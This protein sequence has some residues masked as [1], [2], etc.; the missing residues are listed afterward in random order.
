MVVLGPN[1]H[2]DHLDTNI[3]VS[4][5]SVYFIVV[6][7]LFVVLGSFLVFVVSPNDP[8]GGSGKD[9]SINFDDPL[10][11]YPYDNAT[12]N[13]ITIKLSGTGNFL[14][15]RI[16]MSRA[17]KARYNLGFVDGTFKK[18]SVDASKVSKWERAND[19]VCS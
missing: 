3:V 15:W 11:I 4:F 18:V 1:K 14:P 8:P 2:G 6:R 9:D 19:V 17:F 16:S 10:Y 5:A 12:T 13:I 7:I